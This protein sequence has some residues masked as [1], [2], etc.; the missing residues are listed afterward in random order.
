MSKLVIFARA[1]VGVILILTVFFPV[2]TWAVSDF[3]SVKRLAEQGGPVAQYMLGL[4]YAEG[5]E[6]PQNHVE[7]FK[8]Y[9]KAAEQG[10]AVAQYN[11]G[12]MYYNGQGVPQDYSKAYLWTIL[13]AE[14][15]LEK[16]RSKEAI[17]SKKMTPEQLSQ[18]E[19]EAAILWEKINEKAEAE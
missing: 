14:S 3:E 15:G 9:M 4:R 13:A 19:K 6:V 12:G 11:L 17:L 2:C 8:W 16:A 7:A 10:D 5:Q 18:A 1:A